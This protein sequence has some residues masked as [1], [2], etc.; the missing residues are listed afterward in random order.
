MLTRAAFI[1][2][3]FL[4]SCVPLVE[5]SDDRS[6]LEYHLA[7]I[8]PI[9]KW[10]IKGRMSVRSEDDGS[11]SSF[12]WQRSGSDHRIEMSGSF[13]A[14]RVRVL[15]TSNQT[16][17]EDSKGREVSGNSVDEVLS[18][19]TDLQLPIN[20]LESWIVGKPHPGSS[21]EYR[22]DREGRLVH[23]AQSGWKVSYSRYGEFGGVALPTKCRLTV[24]PNVADGVQTSALEIRLVIRDWGIKQSAS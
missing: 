18:K 24:D 3:A 4:S 17:L 21:A 11:I 15:H 9:D 14:G 7:Q 5:I 1:L 16:L 6:V 19:Y 13:G 8:Q 20:E 12:V 10:L 22:W 23:L 2:A